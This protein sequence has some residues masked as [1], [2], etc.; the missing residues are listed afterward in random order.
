MTTNAEARLCA[1]VTRRR[2]Q[3]RRR[4]Y[5]LELETWHV[6]WLALG[7]SGVALTVAVDTRVR[8][9][10]GDLPPGTQAVYTVALIVCGGFA[11]YHLAGCVAVWTALRR[12]RRTAHRKRHERMLAESY[13]NPSPPPPVSP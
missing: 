5:L 13:R 4:A 8:Q 12:L 11:A 7:L 3:D 10:S 6:S 2:Y 9:V 1:A